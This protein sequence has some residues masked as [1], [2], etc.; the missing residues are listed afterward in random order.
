[1]VIDIDVR[2]HIYHVTMINFK[3]GRNFEIQYNEHV[4]EIK[5]FL[6]DVMFLKYLVIELFT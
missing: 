6:Y 5:W 3:T 2:I 1:M 4:S